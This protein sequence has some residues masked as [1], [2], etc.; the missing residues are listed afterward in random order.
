MRTIWRWLHLGL[1]NAGTPAGRALLVEQFRILTSQVPV[2]YGVLIVE[3]LSVSYVLPSS[4]PFWFRLRCTERACD[5]QRDPNALLGQ[6][7]GFVPTPEQALHYLFKTRILASVINACFSIWTLILFD[8][9]DLASRA[10]LALLVLMGAV[11][12]AYCLG[13][14]PSAARLTLII[15][16]LPISLRLLFSGDALPVCIGLNNCMLVVLLVRMMNTNYRD[17]VDLVASRAM[18]LAEGERARNT[19]IIALEEQANAREIAGRFDTALNNMSQGLCFFDGKQ[20]LI[21]CNRRYLDMYGLRPGE[22]ESPAC[23]SPKSSIFDPR[24]EA[25]RH[26]LRR[27]PGLA[28]QDFVPT[29]PTTRSSNWRMAAFSGSAIDRCRT[30][31]GSRRM[32][33]SLNG[34]GP[35][36]A[37]A[38]SKANAERAELAARSAHTRLIEALDVVPEGLAILDADDRYVLWNKRYAELYTDSFDAIAPGMSFEEV[39][40]FG[41]ARGQY[42]EAEAARRNGCVNVSGATRSRSAHMNSACR[43]T[44]GSVSRSGARRM[45]EVLAYA[46]TSPT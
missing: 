5:R 24:P 26:E 20:R 14:F 17:L 11:G 35:S 38:Q 42:P 34:T 41:L 43:A 44:A 18:L 32:R 23:C 45:V 13:S 6:A 16:A 33:T 46:S 4:L 19:E 10:P 36:R 21:V 22:R 31:V 39:L 25:L 12:S 9:V 3:S 30:T 1:G 2:L 27:L 28:Q 40:R 37:L 15:S 7:R 8:S 29:K